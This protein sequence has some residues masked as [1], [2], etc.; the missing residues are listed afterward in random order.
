MGGLGKKMNPGGG[1]HG[2]YHC[3]VDDDQVIPLMEQRR[4]DHHIVCSLLQAAVWL[5]S[6]GVVPSE[7][8]IQR[9]IDKV[10]TKVTHI[11]PKSEL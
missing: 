3:L 1:C 2:S 11:R 9:D 8:D 4:P 6:R 7:A 10:R 5:S